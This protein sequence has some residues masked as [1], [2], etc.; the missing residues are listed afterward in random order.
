MSGGATCNHD[1][2]RALRR[3]S[4]AL[5]RRAAALRRWVWW[6]SGAVLV[7]DLIVL[8]AAGM[9][10]TAV[11]VAVEALAC[12]LVFLDGSLTGGADRS[13]EEAAR[14]EAACRKRRS[15]RRATALGTV[16]AAVF[17]GLISWLT[18]E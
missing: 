11:L 6:L 5:Q 18:G 8:L 17:V 16:G 9:A 13:A 15:R 12:L 10:A 14:G 1:R 3:R 4:T 7:L 2:N